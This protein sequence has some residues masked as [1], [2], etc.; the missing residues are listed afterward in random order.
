MS[1]ETF[2]KSQFLVSRKVKMKK[3]DGIDDINNLGSQSYGHYPE[4]R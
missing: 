2:T 4:L 1:Q 3:I